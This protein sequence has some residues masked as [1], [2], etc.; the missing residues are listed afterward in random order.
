MASVLFRSSYAIWFWVARV[1]RQKRPMAARMSSA[2]LAHRKGFGSALR[3]A[4]QRLVRSLGIAARR[5]GGAGAGASPR[6]SQIN[7]S[8]RPFRVS[9]LNINGRGCRKARYSQHKRQYDTG[10]CHTFEDRA[11]SPQYHNRGARGIIT[12]HRLTDGKSTSNIQLEFKRM[13]SAS[14]HA[15][16]A[17]CE[18]IHY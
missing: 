9:I 5:V 1:R 18:R 10:A 12:L 13:T 6:R 16:R 8:Y 3:T 17:I 7:G 4:F 15:G 2:V 11:A 14:S